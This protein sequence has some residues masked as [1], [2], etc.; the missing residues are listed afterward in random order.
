MIN[1]K[2]NQPIKLK[3]MTENKTN[4]FFIDGKLSVL[5]DGGAGSS[6]KGKMAAYLV[7]NSHKVNFVCNTF[8]PQASHSTVEVEDGKEVERIYKQLNSCAHFHDKFDKMYI[9]QGSVIDVKALLKEIEMTGLPTSKLGI[10]PV[11]TILQ[12]IDTGFEEGKLDFDGNETAEMHSGTIKYGSTCSGVGAAKARR[13]L[14]RPNVMLARDVEELKPYLCNVSEEIMKRLSDGHSGLLEIAQGFQLSYGLSQFYPYTTSR[15][16]TVASGFDDMM[17]PVHYLGNVCINFRTYPIRIHSYKYITIPEEAENWIAGDK[18]EVPAGS[19][20]RPEIAAKIAEEQKKLMKGAEFEVGDMKYKFILP[21]DFPAIRPSFNMGIDDSVTNVLM[22][23]VRKI[24]EQKMHSVWTELPGVGIFKNLKVVRNEDED[25]KAISINLTYDKFEEILEN[26]E[27]EDQILFSVYHKKVGNQ[28]DLEV[29]E[30][31]IIGTTGKTMKVTYFG[32]HR[33]TGNFIFGTKGFADKENLLTAYKNIDAKVISVSNKEHWSLSEDI[34]LL[35]DIK[36]SISSMAGEE[37]F[38][39][40]F[41]GWDEVQEGK[42]PYEK[43]E[44]YSGDFY[45]DQDE[46]NWEELTRLAGAPETIMECTTLTKLPRRVATFSQTN[47]SEAI[48]Y[49]QSPNEIWIALNFVNY[50]DWN[51]NR[52]TDNVSEKVRE[53]CAANI[54]PVIRQ[55]DNVSLKLLGTSKFTDDT[56][57]LDN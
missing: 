9:G 2:T 16:C 54:S 11:A 4:S 52:V 34:D 7:K 53:F 10:S 30:L 44:S 55:H 50:L 14:R 31:Y 13:V 45:P 6:G 1:V 23:W 15:N 33:V 47:L 35:D 48:Q 49:N 28:N 22:D 19:P 29:G 37:K 43:I 26:E 32:L 40:R 24:N 41:L 5:L 8:F 56:I 36:E 3:V 18:I 42:I 25:G 51:M 12:D 38:V 57:L 17:L 27:G 21:D 20:E 46:L 39:P